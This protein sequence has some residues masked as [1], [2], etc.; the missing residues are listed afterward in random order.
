MK[1][2]STPKLWKW[3]NNRRKS[4]RKALAPMEI[5][6]DHNIGLTFRTNAARNDSS[7]PST[8]HAQHGYD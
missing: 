3:H 5:E 2:V 7:L 4:Y 1:Y 8:N 6:T